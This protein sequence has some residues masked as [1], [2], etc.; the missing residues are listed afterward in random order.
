MSEAFWRR[1]AQR[2]VRS[3]NFA[4]WLFYFAPLCVAGSLGASAFALVLRWE[5]IAPVLAIYVALAAFTSWILARRRFFTE[6][7]ALIRLDLVDGQKMRLVSAFEGGASWPK[8]ITPRKKAVHWRLRTILSPLLI[9][10][11]LPIAVT[12]IPHATTVT[13]RDAP[14]LEPFAWTRAETALEALKEAEVFE[15]ARLEEAQKKLESLRAQP[16]ED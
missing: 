12:S 7:E 3:I 4:W 14:V 2:L 6:R 11:L 5:K 1:R 8:E 9:A 10:V 16:K 13:A 15:K